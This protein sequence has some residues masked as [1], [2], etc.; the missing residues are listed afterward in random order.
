MGG[1]CKSETDAGR[2]DALASDVR[3]RTN[4]ATSEPRPVRAGRESNATRGQRYC[5]TLTHAAN[6]QTADLDRGEVRVGARAFSRRSDLASRRVA[7][8]TV[9]GRGSIVS[10]LKS[11]EGGVRKACMYLRA[12]SFSPRPYV[13]PSS[14]SPPALLTAPTETNDTSAEPASQPVSLPVWTDANYTSASRL[15]SHSTHATLRSPKPCKH[16]T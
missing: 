2:R 13:R 4:N 10:A 9:T 14:R 15:L 16:N 5:S 7:S 1:A 11:G 3:R 8:H 12:G 6:G